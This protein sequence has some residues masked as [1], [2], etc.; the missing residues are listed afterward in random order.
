MKPQRTTQR[1]P[2][3]PL[4][5]E[6]KLVTWGGKNLPSWLVSFCDICKPSD[7]SPCCLLGNLGWYLHWFNFEGTKQQ[8]QNV[9]QVKTQL[10]LGFSRQGF[11]GIMPTQRIRLWNWNTRHWTTFGS[12]DQGHT[13][14]ICSPAL[15]YTDWNNKQQTTR[16]MENKH[17]CWILN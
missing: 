7:A 1:Y 16:T 13:W 14:R 6:P 3:R 2:L 12:H 10:R 15:Y 4:F 17:T 11:I 5:L 9:W 8:R